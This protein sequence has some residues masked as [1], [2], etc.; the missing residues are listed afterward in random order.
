ME[1]LPPLINERHSPCAYPVPGAMLSTSITCIITS[2][3]L[4]RNSIW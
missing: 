1:D 3:N 2:V 4:Q